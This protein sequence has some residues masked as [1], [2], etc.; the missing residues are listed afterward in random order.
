MPWADRFQLPHRKTQQ[1][2]LPH[3]LLSKSPFHRL[4][5]ASSNTICHQAER[6]PIQGWASRIPPTMAQAINQINRGTTISR[7]RVVR[8]G[9][10]RETTITTPPQV[11]ITRPTTIPVAVH[12]AGTTIHRTMPV[13]GTGR[14]HRTITTTIMLMGWAQVG[15]VN[16]KAR[17]TP[18]RRPLN[19]IRPKQQQKPMSLQ[20]TSPL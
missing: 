4:R 9:N 12:Q 7:P 3:L 8:I 2:K 19:P 6:F 15:M 5:S 17:T 18:R 13:A 14:P 11:E 10:P 16:R 20:H 1:G